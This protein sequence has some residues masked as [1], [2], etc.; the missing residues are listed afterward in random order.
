LTHIVSVI[1]PFFNAQKTLER[2]IT[3]VIQQ[4]YRQLD[5]ILINDGSTDNSENIYKDYLNIKGINNI[6]GRIYRVLE[7]IIERIKEAA[8][9]LIITADIGANIKK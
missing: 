9:I 4:S 2:C 7:T 1:I 6:K 8:G 3:S 5:I